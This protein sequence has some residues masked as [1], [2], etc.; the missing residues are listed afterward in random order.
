M[1]YPVIIRRQSE[2]VVLETAVLHCFGLGPNR[3]SVVGGALGPRLKEADMP[4]TLVNQQFLAYE[5]TN[6]VRLEA[7]GAPFESYCLCPVGSSNGV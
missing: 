3:R 6:R 7:A 2:Q 4:V 1:G 5:T